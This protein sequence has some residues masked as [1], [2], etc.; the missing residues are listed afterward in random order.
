[1]KQTKMKI[2]NYFYRFVSV[3]VS[4][5]VMLSLGC[6][7]S[8]PKTQYYS[9][10]PSSVSSSD[11]EKAGE[12]IHSIGIGPIVLPEFLDNIAIVSRTSSQQLRVSGV[13]TWAG[14]LETAMTRVIAGNLSNTTEGR[15]VISFPWDTRVR[16]TYQVRIVVE[17]FSGVRGGDVNLVASWII[18]NTK[19][20]KKMKEGRFHL[21]ESSS[22]ESAG[23]YV[24][25][26]NKVLNTFSSN[27]MQEIA[28]LP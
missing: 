28:T 22:G 3:V 6:S 24:S 11:G 1:M 4:I 8:G 12:G 18:L 9:L 27:L 26:L 17:D 10:F 7:S 21:I 5:V 23:A 25:A 16:P 19:D 14:K 15:H 13:H 20:T 2:K